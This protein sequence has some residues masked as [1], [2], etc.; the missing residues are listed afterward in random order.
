MCVVKT[1]ILCLV[2]MCVL[3]K[4]VIYIFLPDLFNINS[5]KCGKFLTVADN[6]LNYIMESKKLCI[7]YYNCPH[8]YS[9]SVESDSC[10]SSTSYYDILCH[11]R[12]CYHCYCTSG[13]EMMSSCDSSSDSSSDSSCDMKDSEEDLIEVT[14]VD[15]AKNIKD[16]GGVVLMDEEIG[17]EAGVEVEPEVELEHEVENVVQQGGYDADM[18]DN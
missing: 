14:V 9:S 6:Q 13:E 17:D 2:N 5:V 16:V 18:E 1:G 4:Q 10:D 8:C 12:R 11:N 3:S 15:L 7:I